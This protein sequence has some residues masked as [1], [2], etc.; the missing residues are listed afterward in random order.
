MRYITA[1]VVAV[2][3]AVSASAQPI[4]GHPQLG[5]YG[6]PADW[7]VVDSQCWINDPDPIMAGH[8]HV[9]PKGNAY[10]TIFDYGTYSVA[11][12]LKAHHIAGTIGMVSGEHI[13][14][15]VWDATGT[16]QQPV[17]KGDPMGLVEWSGVATIDHTLGDDGFLHIYQFPQHGWAE[18]RI[19]TRTNLDNGDTLDVVAVWPVYSLIDPSV[20]EKPAAEQGRPGVH[21]RTSCVLWRNN[22]ALTG[23]TITEISDYLPLLPIFAPWTTI[24]NGYNY[25]APAGVTFPDQVFEQRLDPDLHHGIPGTIQQHQVIGPNQ[26]KQFLG[27]MVFDPVAMGAGAHKEMAVWTQ[28]LGTEAV[29]AVIVVPVTVGAGVPP[30]PALCTDPNAPNIGQPLPCLPP[31]VVPP[32]VCMDPA[33]TNIG[34]PLPCVF[35]PPV[36]VWTVFSPIFQQLGNQI[37]VCVTADPATCTVI[38]QD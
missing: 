12:T 27:P 15:I 33:A 37:R 22:Q 5:A 9:V 25:T 24:F 32:A 19:F 36:P 23:E 38:K 31:I 6:S 10:A 20:P 17:L 34:Q 11:F 13:R 8:I 2:L 30:P 26:N 3:C 14:S 16:T 21:H 4:F 29:S 1:V 28:P 35:P 7:P 18:D